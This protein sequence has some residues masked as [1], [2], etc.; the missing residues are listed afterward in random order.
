[1]SRTVP[2]GLTSH[3]QGAALHVAWMVKISRADG[4][5]KAFTSHN[6]DLVY[7]GVTYKAAGSF[8]MTQVRQTAGTSIDSMNVN[9]I[10]NSSQITP[11][12]LLAH[13]YDGAMV[14]VFRVRWDQVPLTEAEG[15]LTGFI[16]HIT[17]ERGKFEAEFLGLESLLRTS[18]VEVTSP[19]CRVAVL[20]DSP[21]APGGTFANGATLASMRF[22]RT[23]TAVSGTVGVTFGSDSNPT[24]YYNQGLVTFTTGPNTGLVREIKQH[25]LVSGEAVLWLAE[26]FYDDMAVGHV[27]L[28]ER[29]CD[30]RC[31]TCAAIQVSAINFQGEPHLPGT[32]KM[33]EKGPRA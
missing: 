11:A 6:E 29:G 14:E 8:R 5:I 13:R 19:L 30:R 18:I 21:C 1:L 17:Y 32:S 26:P 10:L 20:G 28:L 33:M 16:G 22:S 2:A 3:M 24:G 9:G 31:Q 12:E 7:G 4:V 15:H 23:V 27:A 25:V